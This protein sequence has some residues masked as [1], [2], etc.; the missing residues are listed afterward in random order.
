MERGPSRKSASHTTGNAAVLLKAITYQTSSVAMPTKTY[1]STRTADAISSP[2]RNCDI[3]GNDI[4][5]VSDDAIEPDYGDLEVFDRLVADAHGYRR[6]HRQL[7]GA[8]GLR[9][10]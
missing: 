6:V 1:A 3:Y 7:P 10:R 9:L 2:N 8:A 5:D 4:F